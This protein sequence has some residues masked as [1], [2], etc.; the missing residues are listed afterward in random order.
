MEKIK[1]YRRNWERT[2]GGNGRTESGRVAG[3]WIKGEKLR[4]T[5]KGAEGAAPHHLYASV[6]RPY[7]C[8]SLTVYRGPEVS[9]AALEVEISVTK[10]WS[11]VFKDC[12]F[13]NHNVQSH[14]SGL[15]KIVV[16]EHLGAWFWKVTVVHL[17]LRDG[18]IYCIR[19]PTYQLLLHSLV[20]IL[21][22][23]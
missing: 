19:H 18:N 6:D 10:M 2:K 11:Q 12:T 5:Q 1:I 15:L 4:D 14:W 8:H 21:W 13:Q 16:L 20:L 9:T 22:C 3:R 17:G 7:V 23:R